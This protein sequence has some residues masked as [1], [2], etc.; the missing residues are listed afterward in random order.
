MPYPSRSWTASAG[1]RTSPRRWWARPDAPCST[2]TWRRPTNSSTMTTRWTTYA[3]PSSARSSRRSGA[4]ASTR[5]WRRPWMPRCW[6]ATTSGSPTTRWRWAGGSSTSSP[7]RCPRA[8]TGRPPEPT[9]LAPGR[10]RLRRRLLG[11]RTGRTTRLDP[12]STTHTAGTR[13]PRTIWCAA[14]SGLQPAIRVTRTPARKAWLLLALAGDGLLSGGCRLRVKIAATGHQRLH[15]IVELVEQ[16]NA[17]RD[18]EAR[19]GLVIDVVEV[20]DQRTLRIAV[21]GHQHRLAGLQVGH[22]RRLPVGKHA[23]DDVLEALMQRTLVSRDVGV[24]RVVELAE[25]AVGLDGR[26]RH[27]VA[28]TPGHELLLAVLVADLGLVEA[29][30]GAVVA[31]VEAPAALHR[32]PEAIGLVK[33]QV[34]GVDGAAQQRGVHDVGQQSLLGQQLATMGCLPHAL[35]VEVDVD[36]AGE[37]VFRVPFALAMAEQDQL[38]G[39]VHD[40][41]EPSLGRAAPS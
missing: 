19:D 40:S 7:A 1:C 9:C 16:R 21:G 24:A 38:R 8:T 35:L 28:A 4:T 34:R 29:L 30:Q 32:N 5:P 23:L 33:G 17:G 31:L 25:L 41:I 14:P 20:L 10:H 15:V 36:P 18:V 3:A 12:H 13:G 22:D 2:A 27:V 39:H 11:R 6:G 26:R 37:Q